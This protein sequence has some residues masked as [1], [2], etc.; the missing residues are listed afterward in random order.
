MGFLTEAQTVAIK[1]VRAR[2][3]N[4]AFVLETYA[5][6]PVTDLYGELVEPL[7]IQTN[8]LGDWRWND[9]LERRGRPGGGWTAGGDLTLAC[10]IE[11]A[12]LFMLAGVR[13]VVPDRNGLLKRLEIHNVTEYPGSGECVVTASVITRG[14]A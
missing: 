14:V 1:T 13:L 4:Q 2:A 6:V 12:P 3:W 10:D 8:L 5:T 11:H 7:P 9:Q